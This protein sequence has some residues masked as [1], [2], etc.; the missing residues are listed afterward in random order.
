MY[1]RVFLE[2]AIPPMEIRY[3][4][5]SYQ[6]QYWLPIAQN[7]ALMLNGELGWAHGYGGKPLP[8]FKNFYAGGIGSVRGYEQSSLGPR[9]VNTDGS[10]DSIGGNRRLIANAEYY[11]P[12][13][14]T[15]Q[16]RS[17]RMSTF[18]DAGQVWGVDEKFELSELRYSAGLAFSWSSPVGPLK[19][20]MGWP[21]NK[22]DTDQTERFQFQLGT[23]F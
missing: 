19:L 15:G 7:S 20:S 22:D 21:L 5:A 9:I 13:P 2:V 10:L 1:Q 3:A 17:F 23:V 11:F 18:L 12:L 14:G 8:F 4:K 6:H 16:D